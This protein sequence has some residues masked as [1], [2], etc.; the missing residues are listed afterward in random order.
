MA[1][2]KILPVCENGF[3]GLLALMTKNLAHHLYKFEHAG[4]INVV[5]HAIGIFFEI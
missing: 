4:V 5:K 2:K 1:D 3:M